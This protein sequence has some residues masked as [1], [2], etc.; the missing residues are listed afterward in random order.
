[1]CTDP[2][3]ES[4]KLFTKKEEIKISADNLVQKDKSNQTKEVEE[5]EKKTFEKK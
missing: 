3:C 4:E 5:F 1:M 2:G